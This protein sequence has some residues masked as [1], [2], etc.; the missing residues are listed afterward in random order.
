M[1][2]KVPVT[3]A[4]RALRAAKVAFEPRP[5]D[6]EPPGGTARSA[7]ALGVDEHRVIKTLVLETGEGDPLIC[8]M[9]GDREVSLRGLARHLGTKTV[10]PC[11]PAVAEKHSGYKVGGTSP[12]GTRKRMRVLVERSI[13]EL[14]SILINGGKRGF[15]VELAPAV[16]VDVLGG[17]PVDAAAGG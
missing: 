10:R 13:L 14:D 7:A 5:Y 12:F 16:L 3:A 17:E 11:D 4:V 15:L 1:A 9:H 8:L 6:Y 2:P